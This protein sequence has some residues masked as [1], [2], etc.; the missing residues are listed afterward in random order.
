[1]GN[2]KIGIGEVDRHRLL[3]DS[4]NGGVPHPISATVGL[5]ICK[6]TKSFWRVGVE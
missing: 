3:Y 4:T 5:G 1:M 2:G 6:D